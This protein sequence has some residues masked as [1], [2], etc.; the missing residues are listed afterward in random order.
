M[1][2]TSN[3]QNE[4]IDRVDSTT[5]LIIDLPEFSFDNLPER[6]A[7][8]YAAKV[9]NHIYTDYKIVIKYGPAN[10]LSKAYCNN[11]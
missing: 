3:S 10:I 2:P 9:M 8:Y 11:N 7:K 5:S 4:L 1:F 6:N